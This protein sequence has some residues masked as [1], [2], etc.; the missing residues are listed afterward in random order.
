MERQKFERDKIWQH[1]SLSFSYILCIHKWKYSCKFYCTFLTHIGKVFAILAAADNA[2]PLFSGILYTQVYNATISTAPATIFWVTFASQMCVFFLTLWVYVLN[3]MMLILKQEW[4]YI[5]MQ[6]F[7]ILIS[8][9]IHKNVLIS[10]YVL[11][12]VF[13]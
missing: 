8:H 2:V 11:N 6:A 7:F 5:S 4:K 9:Q 13:F 1:S 10:R 12:K 3:E